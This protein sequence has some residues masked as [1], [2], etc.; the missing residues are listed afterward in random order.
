LLI[1]H[2]IRKDQEEEL[3]MERPECMLLGTIIMPIFI[4]ASLGSGIT[5]GDSEYID[6]YPI[7][8]DYQES[9][10]ASGDPLLLESNISHSMVSPLL[11][12]AD[13]PTASNEINVNGGALSSTPPE[14]TQISFDLK[15]SSVASLEKNSLDIRDFDN[16]I[17][18]TLRNNSI[19]N[20]ILISSM[21][22]ITSDTIFPENVSLV[23]VR[24]GKFNISNG[25]K[26]VING[27]L[28]AGLYPIF[29]NKG[30]V[31]F[32]T[33][34]SGKSTRMVYPQWWGAAADGVTDDSMPINLASNS[35][36][37]YGGIVYFSPGTYA[38]KESIN[39]IQSD[40]TFR[41]EGETS[42]LKAIADDIKLIYINGRH[43][44][45]IEKLKLNGNYRNN[46][47]KITDII[48]AQ[49][50]IYFNAC[51]N[52]II[53]DCHFIN[54]GHSSSDEHYKSCA[55]FGLFNNQNI[56]IKDNIVEGGKNKRGGANICLYQKNTENV[57][58][59]GN[60][61]Y[62]PVDISILAFMIDKC[63]GIIITNN[64]IRDSSRHGIMVTYGG[65]ENKD[66]IIS[67]NIIYNTGSTGIYNNGG[68]SILVS[69]N[70]LHSCSG[71]LGDSNLW[72]NGWSLSGAIYC[73]GVGEK[74]I[75]NNYI[76][77]TGR[78]INGSPKEGYGGQPV[79][80]SCA[81]KIGS[82]GGNSLISNNIIDGSIGHGIYIYHHQ[83]SPPKAYL[84]L[85]I[86]NNRITGIARYGVFIQNSGNVYLK[87]F[88]FSH[89]YVEAGVVGLCMI[90]NS[91]FTDIFDLQD[92][93]FIGNQNKSGNGILFTQSPFNGRIKN[94]YINN[95]NNGAYIYADTANLVGTT[96]DFSENIITNCNNGIRYYD[97]KNEWSF[98]INNK[99][100]EN[101]IND[102]RPDQYNNWRD[103]IATSPYKLFYDYK[104]PETGTWRVGDMIIIPNPS[105]GKN[106]GW[107]CT[108]AGTPGKWTSMGLMSAPTSTPTE[109]QVLTWSNLTSQW[110]PKSHSYRTLVFSQDIEYNETGKRPSIKK[111]FR[112]VKDSQQ[113][114]KKWRVIVSLWVTGNDTAICRVKIG[115]NAVELKCAKKSETILGGDI[116]IITQNDTPL[117]STIELWLSKGSKA[118]AHLSYINIYAVY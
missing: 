28:T 107:I 106:S 10:L 90:Y 116:P 3:I 44:I 12:N 43:H 47:S 30:K 67:N 56:T 88:S 39:I 118:T 36:S 104:P 68:R 63:G 61:C 100:Y 55:I 21:V 82:P 58:I 80:M 59:T 48:Q 19:N 81:I 112:L 85:S 110:S 87:H 101:K 22:N 32:G 57:I 91:G 35:L 73:S 51:K 40:T 64:I 94:N 37:R 5:E 111:T 70:I 2:H 7:I 29:E 117:N 45:V 96:I 8:P 89:N 86:Y 26:L 103:A 53:R 83:G 99:V 71:N 50:G 66:A 16:V 9:W 92:N 33:S 78:F 65:S 95:W 77:N 46:N 18:A 102:Y 74:I 109:G 72:G 115:G 62:G 105:A 41:G 69:G 4:F 97:R 75:T 25:K 31:L 54:F 114:P 79:N 11:D 20:T 93:I 60:R 23:V 15:D 49:S 38:I 6:I 98:G 1:N 34:G 84:N 42:I 13:M 113:P 27:E 76:Y 52:L 17:S 108:V 24:G 14:M